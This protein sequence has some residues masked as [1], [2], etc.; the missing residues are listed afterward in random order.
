MQRYLRIGLMAAALWPTAPSAQ[1]AITYRVEAATPRDQAIAPG[2]T[3]SLSFTLT[4]TATVGGAASVGGHYASRP[5]A[6]AGYE[7]DAIDARCG[8][9][10]LESDT[11]GSPR[12]VFPVSDIPPAASLTCNYLITR[13]PDSIDDLG[14]RLCGPGPYDNYCD[15]RIRRGTLP[16]LSLEVQA[17]PALASSPDEALVRVRM[18]NA[19]SL[20]VASRVVTTEC[21]E[22]EGGIFA[23]GPFRVETDFPGACPRA[24]RGAG[25]LNFTGQRFHSYGFLL[26]PAPA[27]GE[28]SCLLRLRYADSAPRGK[29]VALYFLDDVV[30]L[31]SGGRGFDAASSN[32]QTELGADT[33]TGA[34]NIPVPASAIPLLV[35]ALVLSGWRRL[36]HH[37]TRSPSP[38]G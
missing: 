15:R 29:S 26:G 18:R 10:T 34:V 37:R 4:N 23:P 5:E 20:A 11:F 19:S 9:P 22:F 14:F 16:D 25:C 35:L 3:G 27:G 6:L 38:R 2:G 12:L 8:A 33:R 21:S 13:H 36:G 31:E 7:F 24:D 32:D 30:S 28:S 17:V 1:A